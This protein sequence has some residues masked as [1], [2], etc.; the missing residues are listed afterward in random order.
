MCGG[1]GPAKDDDRG[2]LKMRRRPSWLTE[3]ALDHSWDTYRISLPYVFSVSDMAVYRLSNVRTDSTALI[4]R[5][6]KDN[7]FDG[8][9][10]VFVD[11]SVKMFFLQAMD[12]TK[13]LD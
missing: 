1:T 13:S 4:S 8:N 6:S 10:T 9:G 5:N 7:F 3:D 11:P 2:I 12:Q